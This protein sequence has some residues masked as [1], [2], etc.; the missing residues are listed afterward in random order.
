MQGDVIAREQALAA[1]MSRNSVR[2]KADC[3]RWQRIHPGVYALEPRGLTRRATLW[4]A[5]LWA[6]EGA[7]LSYESAA[8]VHG[9]LDSPCPTI[10]VAVP[11]DRRP[12]ARSGIQVHRMERVQGLRTRYPPGW[13]PATLPADTILDLAE[14]ARTPDELCNWISRALRKSAVS[15]LMLLA[16]LERRPSA[17][18]RQDIA[19]LIRDA[20]AGTHSP[21][22]YRYDREVERAHGLPASCRQK[23][24]R[25][26]DGTRG[27]RDRYYEGYQVIVELDGRAYHQDSWADV[28]RDNHAAAVMGDQT[29]R[30]GWRHVR[31]DPCGT[32]AVVADVLKHHGGLRIRTPAGKAAP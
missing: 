5:V 7:V 9:L 28:D 3:G 10:H 1:G 32:A 20:A 6:G 16:M 18:H 21:L 23:P 17:R 25:K 11:P 30:F 27:Y 13:L 15:D 24:Y 19:H 31:F 29:L 26:P 12:R 14:A 2:S 4:A 8:E 22:E